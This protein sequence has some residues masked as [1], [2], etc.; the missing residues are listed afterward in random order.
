MHR[1]KMEVD[2]EEKPEVQPEEAKEKEPDVKEW[3]E[4]TFV[5]FL[6]DPN[7]E[8]YNK[9]FPKE[10]PLSKKKSSVCAITG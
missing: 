2:T 8:L 9:A 4:R 1:V 5:T 10:K 6:N 7:D 3:C